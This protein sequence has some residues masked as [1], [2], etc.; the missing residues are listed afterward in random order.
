MKKTGDEY[1][2][3]EEFRNILDNYEESAKSGY[4]LYMDAD[5][6]A[7][8]AD[9]YTRA[10]SKTYYTHGGTAPDYT[11]TRVE[12]PAANPKTRRSLSRSPAAWYLAR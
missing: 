7:D 6:L 5:D 8:I 10:V 3:S 11:Y 1:F 12:T 4:P 9:Y 2:D